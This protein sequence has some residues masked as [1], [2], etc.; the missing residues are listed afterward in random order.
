MKNNSKK[1]I[2]A[3]DVSIFASVITTIIGIFFIVLNFILN[4][5]NED[6][7]NS[8]VTIF[9]IGLC[10]LCANIIVRKLEKRRKL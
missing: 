6:I 5:T 1:K 3:S 7:Y 8:A 2:T 4:I 10:C 9:F